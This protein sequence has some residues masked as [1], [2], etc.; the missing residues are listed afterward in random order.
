M[1]KAGK[2]ILLFLTVACLAFIFSNSLQSSTRSSAQSGRV[3]QF[4]SDLYEALTGKLLHP[5]RITYAI[6]KLAH[7]LEFA[8]LGFLGTSSLASFFGRVRGRAHVL[9]FWG[10]AVAVT[11]EFIQRFSRGRSPQVSDITLDFCGFLLGFALAWLISALLARKRRK[12][13]LGVSVD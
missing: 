6:R 3:V 8:L 2:F 5:D 4:V 11:D 10:L 7:F 12:Y 1:K 9:L 13:E